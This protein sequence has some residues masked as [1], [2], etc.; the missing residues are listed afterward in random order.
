M[1]EVKLGKEINDNTYLQINSWYFAVALLFYLADK[2][3]K[4]NSKPASSTTTTKTEAVAT[5]ALQHQRIFTKRWN[6][7]N[8]NCFA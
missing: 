2:L 3:I 4:Q 8:Y 1:S 6:S 5:S 7:K